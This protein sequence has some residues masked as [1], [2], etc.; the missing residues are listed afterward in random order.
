MFG[1]FKRGL[2]ETNVDL[3]GVVYKE[4]GVDSNSFGQQFMPHNICDAKA[5]MIVNVDE[6]Q[7]S[8]LTI[9]DSTSGSGRLLIS[10]AQKISSGVDAIFHARD[11][12]SDCA[13][14]ITQN[15]YF[16][17]IDGYAVHGRSLKIEKCRI[18]QIRSTTH[19]GMIRELGRNEASGM[20]HGI[21]KKI[22]RRE[23]RL[24]LLR[25]LQS[26]SRGIIIQYSRAYLTRSIRPQLRY[27][28]LRQ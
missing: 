22:K 14:M 16:F 4:L 26:D 20:V 1:E 23:F 2:A 11:K 5:A 27:K 13:K 25:L 21:W 10:V 24:K 17:D 12:D 3:L 6:T 15:M 9:A 7:K 19:S 18:W 8:V 28:Y